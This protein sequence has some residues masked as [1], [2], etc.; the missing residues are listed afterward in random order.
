MGL[1]WVIMMSIL[2]SVYLVAGL[3]PE[4]HRGPSFESDRRLMAVEMAHSTE[5]VLGGIMI[6]FLMFR[7]GKIQE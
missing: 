2:I 6:L 3:V 5:Y 4:H 7:I 1:I